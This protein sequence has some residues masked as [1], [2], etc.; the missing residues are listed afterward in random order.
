MPTNISAPAGD[1]TADR[2]VI[3]GVDGHPEIF[4]RR[5]TEAEIIAFPPGKRRKRN[6]DVADFLHEIVEQARRALAAAAK[7]ADDAGAAGLKPGVLQLSRLHPDSDD[8]VPSRFTLDA[9]ALERMVEVAR[10]D[11]A[12]GHNVYVEGRTVTTDV[13][14]RSRGAITDTGAVFALVIDSDGDKGTAGTLPADFEPSVIVETSPGNRHYWLFLEKAISAKEGQRL[15]ERVRD[16]VKADHDTGTVTQPYR[17]AG[18]LNYPSKKKRERGRTEIHPTRILPRGTTAIRLW[19]V[20]EIESTFP[21]VKKKSN[22]QGNRGGHFDESDLPK[23]LMDTIKG[24]VE[25]GKRSHSFF[26]V[27]AWL[28]ELGWT[29]GGIVSLLQKYPDGIAKKY[30]KR[31]EKE[32]ERAF[33][34]IEVDDAD[35]LAAMNKDNCVVLEGARA[36]ILRFERQ[37]HVY[38]NRSYSRLVPTFLQVS[39][40][41]LLYLNQRVTLGKSVVD[42][43][44]WW[45]MH[46]GRRQYEGV[47]FVPGGAEV[48]DRKLNLWN[49]WGVTPKCGDWSLMREHIYQVLAARDDDANLYIMNWLTWAIQNP[50]DRAEVALVFKGARGSGKGTLGN[51]LM[52]LYGQH[53]HHISSATQLAGRFNAHMRDCCYLF[54]DEAYWP[55][56]KS[57][58]GQLKRLITDPD[59]F[60]E[61]KGRDQISVVNMLH[62]VMATNEDWVVPAG[63]KERRFA[64]FDVA[65]THCQDGEYFDPLY[66]QLDAG[67][68]EAMLFDLLHRDIGDWHPRKEI[69]RNAAL[70]KQQAESLSP[71]DAWW[72]GLL[73]D[74][75]LTGASEDEPNRAISNEHEENRF[76]PTY[77][78]HTVIRCKGL[79]DHARQASPKLRHFTDDAL[80]RYL[81][82]QGCENA[83][84]VRG[85]RGWTFKPLAE[86]RKAW[87]ERFPGWSWQDPSATD[88]TYTAAAGTNADGT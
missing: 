25:K 87:E 86:H 72:V 77:G 24:S 19:S 11:S 58:E 39:D 9:D 27:V 81:K 46:P 45:L 88:W 71:L 43:G 32:V 78:R 18:T 76:D 47:V 74:G 53:A 3:G 14:G 68:Y 28:K 82:K 12:A 55:G 84:K 57:A 85:K 35:Q 51:T 41:K 33:D 38:R 48:V 62:V 60:I 20:D 37:T 1:A 30:E 31:L 80:G 73:E 13:R 16:A 42:L 7:T 36:R 66:A 34:K 5:A 67:G 21:E 6:D 83:R 4:F 79:Y 10:A 2:F 63:E 50:A 29:V 17:V 59:L 8:L 44:T 56:D 40:F 23:A 15:G 69:P 22:G 75:Q 70:V 61:A 65:D 52:R 49:G 54:A 64:L 26:R